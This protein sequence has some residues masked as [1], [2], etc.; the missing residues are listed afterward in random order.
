LKMWPIIPLFVVFLLTFPVWAILNRRRLRQIQRE[1][2]TYVQDEHKVLEMSKGS[3][4]GAYAGSI[5]AVFGWLYVT[6]YFA[7]DW[8]VLWTVV[9]AAV[10]IFWA[11]AK[12]C[13]RSRQQFYRVQMAVFVL[14]GLIHLLVVNLRW[15]TWK[16]VLQY[17]HVV[18]LRQMNL[19]IGAVIA[20]MVVW[21]LILDFRLQKITKKEHRD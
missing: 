16:A 15:E 9:T 20:G 6:A 18:T 19:I 10:V 3:I 14:A 1:E 13:L 7:R 2:G 12:L 5:F 11:A 17:H 8:T 4:Y 21:A